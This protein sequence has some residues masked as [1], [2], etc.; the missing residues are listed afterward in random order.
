MGDI[1]TIRA[2]GNTNPGVTSLQ[3]KP[4]DRHRT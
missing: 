3:T 2:N 1:I 4:S